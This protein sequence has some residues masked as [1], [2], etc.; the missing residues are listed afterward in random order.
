VPLWLTHRH[1]QTESFRQAV[2]FAQ[3]AE[4]KTPLQRDMSVQLRMQN[5]HL[6]N[7]TKVYYVVETFPQTNDFISVIEEKLQTAFLHIA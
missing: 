3:P 7:H 4:L 6:T 2:L 1:T 5:C